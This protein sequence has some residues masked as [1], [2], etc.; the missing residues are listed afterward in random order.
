[1]NTQQ[2]AAYILAYFDGNISIASAFVAKSTVGGKKGAKDFRRTFKR[3]LS[4][5][6]LSAENQKRFSN[7]FNFRIYK[8]EGLS[9]ADWKQKRTI[10]KEE[11]G[12]RVYPEP[13]CTTTTTGIQAVQDRASRTE[14]VFKRL[15]IPYGIT[16]KYALNY[17]RDDGVDFDKV[18]YAKARN[19]PVNLSRDCVLEATQSV[20]QK[21]MSWETGTGNNSGQAATNETLTEYCI[22]F[23]GV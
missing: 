14:A 11:Y 10:A 15:G 21:K 16:V 6:E 3:A 7:A 23:F 9:S 22:R 17:Q 5:K 2:I 13:Y 20:E 12:G 4:N 8:Q 1:M 18:F 19:D